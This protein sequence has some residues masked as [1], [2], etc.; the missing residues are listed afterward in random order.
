MNVHLPAQMD[1]AAFLAWAEGREEPHE[2]VDG[3]VVMMTRPSR[4][5]AI[6]VGNLIV[7]LRRRL[8]PRLWTVVAE[9]GL[10]AG[11]KTL[12]FPDVMVDRAGGSGGDLTARAPALLI[13]V[14]SPS[15]ALFDLGDKA[16]EFLGIAT[17][18]AYLVLAQDERK[19]WTWIRAGEHFPSGPVVTDGEGA[20]IRVPALA[21]ELDL[22]EIYA[23]ITFD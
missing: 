10:D 8:D 18:A 1:K 12:R 22:S 4:A 23:G 3:R 5:H 20:I 7:A 14:L 16:A 6:I 15:T 2:L 11:P 19:A 17:L 21:L 13:E 9:F